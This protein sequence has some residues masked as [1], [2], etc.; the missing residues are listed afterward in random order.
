M[1]VQLTLDDKQMAYMS[2][3]TGLQAVELTAEA[4]TLLKWAIDEA[5][6][7]RELVSAD[8]HG[9]RLLR[10]TLPSLEKVRSNA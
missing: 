3:L 7:G 2:A 4:L 5:A 6:R 9:G 8:E 10:V 1:I